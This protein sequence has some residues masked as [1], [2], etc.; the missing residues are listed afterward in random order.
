MKMEKCGLSRGFP[1][2]PV[3]GKA[4]LDLWEKADF[5]PL[6]QELFLWALMKNDGFPFSERALHRPCL[7]RFN[8]PATYPGLYGDNLLYETLIMG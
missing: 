6:F 4:T 7:F 8:F 1:K 5:R 3:F 2:T